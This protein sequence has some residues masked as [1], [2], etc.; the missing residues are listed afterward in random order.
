MKGDVRWGERSEKEGRL[1]K[2]VNDRNPGPKAPPMSKTDRERR[3][4]RRCQGK[5]DCQRSDGEE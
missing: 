2:L 1:V 5:S 4:Q 3:E